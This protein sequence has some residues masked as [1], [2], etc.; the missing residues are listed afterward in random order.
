MTSSADSPTEL[1]I[2]ILGRRDSPTDGVED[3]CAFLGQA[4]RPH[5]VRLE[6]VRVRWFDCGWVRALSQVW[7]ESRTW[8]KNWVLLQH[9]AMAWSRRG[10]PFGEVAVAKILRR[11]GVRT[12]VI[13][14]EPLPQGGP[15]WIDQFRRACQD[16]VVRALYREATKAIFADPLA[17]V[18]WLP[19]NRLKA[20]LIPIGAN[21]PGCPS[22]FVAIHN[23]NGRSKTV[24]VFCLSNLPNRTRELRDIH[25]AMNFVHEHGLKARVLFLGRGTDDAREEIEQV[26]GA[27][28]IEVVN[29]GLQ[30]AEKVSEHLCKSDAMLCVRGP[31]YP[32]RGSAIAGIACG[33][34][35]VAYAGAAEGTL[36]EE[37]GVQLVP[38]GNREALGRALANLLADDTTRIILR[39]RSLEAYRRNFSWD[40]IATAFE[41]SFRQRDGAVK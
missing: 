38:Y 9:T 39:E 34:P 6:M 12:A 20:S 8:S 19:P 24:V 2:A 27:S 33:V 25:H 32:R 22:E 18:P 23:R 13:F 11:H 35:I 14:H 26:F 3:Y 37:A 29:L 15:R 30:S 28:P 17:T 7:R 41:E 36:L 16:W 10:F 31:L 1:W 4:L 5:G 40:M 21:I